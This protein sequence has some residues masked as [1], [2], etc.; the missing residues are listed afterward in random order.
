MT[1]IETIRKAVHRLFHHTKLEAALGIQISVSSKMEDAI[2]LWTQ[3]FLDEPPW[4]DEKTGKETLSLPSSIASEIARLTTVEM[5]STVSGS[6]RADFINKQY[7]KV[8]E[9]AR[10][11]TEFAV[12]IG[13]IALKPYISGKNIPVTVVYAEDF[14]PTTFDSDGDVTGACF[15]DYAFDENYRYTRVEEHGFDKAG[16]YHIRNKCFRQQISDITSGEEALGDEVPLSEVPEWASISDDVPIGNIE[17]PLFA[18]F[19]TPYANH[20]EP[21]SPLGV[22]AFSRAV[23]LIKRADRLWSEILWEYEG[24]ELALN[25]SSNLFPRD[26]RGNPIIP[27][28]R[29]RMFKN[30]FDFDGENFLQE[31]APQFRDSSL[32]N[33]LNRTVQRIEF[34]CGLAY[35]TISDPAMIE[36]TATE[37]NTA[38]QRSYSTIHDTQ[39][40]LE[41]ALRNLVYAIDALATLYNLAPAGQYE[42]TF[43]WDD[44]IIVDAEAERLRDR[45]EVRDG[46]MAKWEYRVKWYGETE[47]TAKKMVSQMQDAGMSDDEI[48]D[49]INEPEADEGKANKKE[50]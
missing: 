1:I 33:G 36:K 22:A 46:L 8:I 18:Y 17:K 13:G 42:V 3:M 12:G 28:G 14:F 2:D 24:G 44:S 39:G 23:S 20:I 30:L 19:K 32:F 41:K 43:Q 48:L 34:L 37:I 16:V 29:E 50:S 26:I 45:E 10:T 40:N 47:A 6:P 27:E 15:L 25:A 35:G 5:V 4:K 11:T 38:K 7:Q 49:F 9:K 31:F 21:K